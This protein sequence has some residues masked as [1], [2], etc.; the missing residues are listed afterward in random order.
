MTTFETLVIT[1]SFLSLIVAMIALS[2]MMS[3]KK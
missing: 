2:Y 1:I 3:Q